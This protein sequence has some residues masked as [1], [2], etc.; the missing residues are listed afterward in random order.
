MN[1]PSPRKLAAVALLALLPV[2]AYILGRTSPVVALS[3]V[4]VL[5]I[6]FSLYL[7]LSPSETEVA[8]ANTKG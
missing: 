4:S 6:G 1:L 5:I 3:L 2:V 7:M 8:P